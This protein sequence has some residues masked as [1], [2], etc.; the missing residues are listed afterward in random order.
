M[1]ATMIAKVII[2]TIIF[3]QTSFGQNTQLTR[4]YRV[5]AYKNGNSGITSTSNETEVIPTMYIYVPNSFTPNGDG[6]NDFFSV[7]GEAIQSFT[8]EIYNRWGQLIFQTRDVTASWDGTYKGQVVPMGA[9]V[10]KLNASSITGRKTA[11]EGTINVI[12]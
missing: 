9:Y 8:L 1:K 5:I 4:K 10:Y 7:K 2:A 6:I 11:K 3:C 12:L